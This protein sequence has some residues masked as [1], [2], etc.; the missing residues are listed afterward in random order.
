MGLSHVRIM[1]EFADQMHTKLTD[2]IDNFC[3]A[4]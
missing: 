4:Q 2:V 1:A 3:L